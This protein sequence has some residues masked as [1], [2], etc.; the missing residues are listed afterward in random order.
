M[1]TQPLT[2]SCTNYRNSARPIQPPWLVQTSSGLIIILLAMRITSFAVTSSSQLKRSCAPSLVLCFNTLQILFLSAEHGRKMGMRWNLTV[3]LEEIVCFG[4]PRS[5]TTTQKDGQPKTIWQRQKL[6]PW[7]K[8]CTEIWNQP[9]TQQRYT[10]RSYTKKE[11]RVILVEGGHVTG[12]D[13]TRV[14][15][16]MN[17]QKMNCKSCQ[18]QARRLP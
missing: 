9:I 8:W 15:S 10:V 1:K 11:D 6:K 4:V 13:L 18:S 17:R 16:I 14:A 3:K 12:L 2:S 7:K 5:S